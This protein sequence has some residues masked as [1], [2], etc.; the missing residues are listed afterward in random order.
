MSFGCISINGLDTDVYRTV[1]QCGNVHK[2]SL[3]SEMQTPQE[4]RGSHLPG[5]VQQK[6]PVY[7]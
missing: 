3:Q 4:I 1:Y 6:I 7:V 5:C 2:L